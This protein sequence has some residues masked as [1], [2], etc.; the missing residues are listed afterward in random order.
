MKKFWKNK[1]F[2]YGSLSV[3][4]TAAVVV[5]IILVNAV[6]TLLASHYH[7]YI[8]TTEEQLYTLSDT[9][10][11]LLDEIFK[12]GADGKRCSTAS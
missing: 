5:L 11:A 9:S 12:E 2:R 7:W 10:K 6:F 1:K 8:D 4:F 3:A